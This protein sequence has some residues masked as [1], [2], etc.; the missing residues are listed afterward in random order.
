MNKTIEFLVHHGAAVLFAAV[1]VEQMGIPL[2]A[3]PWL[4]AAGALVGSGKMSWFVAFGPAVFGSILADLIWFYL[5]RHYG[6]RVLALLCRISLEPDSCVRQTQNVFTR[7][8]LRGLVVAKFIPGL[9]TLAPPLAGN[10]GFSIPRFLFYDGLGSILYVGGLMLVGVLFKQQLEA[11]MA[12]LGSLGT[13]ALLLLVGLI[14]LY[15]G[16]KYFQRHR[17]LRELRMARITVDEL[18]QKQEEGEDLMILDLRS[19]AALEEDPS[20]IRGALHLNMDEVDGHLKEVPRDRDIILYCSCPN[21]VSA[22]RVAL[23]LQ[24]KGFSRVRPLLGGFEA[25]RERNYP[26]EPRV[27]RVP[28]VAPIEK[29]KEEFL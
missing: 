24:R 26:V 13:G 12:A 23:L 28:D 16:Y 15:I 5:G 10:S 6:Q 29:K 9:S 20:L 14:S 4:F 25:W 17:L 18:H 2:P 11:I 21:E 7:Y 19:Q 27:A 8:G 1:F 22:A 3:L